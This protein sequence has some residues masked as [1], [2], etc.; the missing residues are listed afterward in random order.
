[1]ENQTQNSRHPIFEP[2]ALVLLSLATVGT[3][4]CS[5]Q[6]TVW[7]AASQRAMNLSNASSRRAA[8]NELKSSQMAML[9]VMLFTQYLNARAGSNETLANFYSSRFRSEAKAAFEAWMSTHPFENSNA[10]PHP[11]VADLYHP[12]LLD[13]A[14]KAEAESQSQWQA[15]SEAGRTG[16]SYVLITVMLASALFCAGTAPKFENLR[17]RRMVVAFGLGTFVIAAVRLVTLPFH[18]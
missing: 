3:A 5:F 6:A 8:A 17:I 11:F 9:D 1:M 13:E 14:R 2:V 15:A 7:G 18:L 12:Q 10:P 16:R 4:W